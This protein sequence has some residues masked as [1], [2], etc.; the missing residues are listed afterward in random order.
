MV[1]V[2]SSGLTM[3]N[4]E[5]VAVGT[6]ITPE[7][8]FNRHSIWGSPN[9]TGLL[10][11]WKPTLAGKKFVPSKETMQKLPPYKLTEVVS[12]TEPLDGVSVAVLAPRL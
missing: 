2:L 7:N 11:Q 5:E 8:T 3:P 9:Q 10:W 6:L 4:V 12:F 1:I